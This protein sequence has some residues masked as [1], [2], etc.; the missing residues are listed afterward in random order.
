MWPVFA[1]HPFI[2]SAYHHNSVWPLTFHTKIWPRFVSHN[3]PQVKKPCYLTWPSTS[4]AYLINIESTISHLY[5][6]CLSVIPLSSCFTA[7]ELWPDI[8]PY[9]TS[10]P[11]KILI[12]HVHSRSIFILNDLWHL[13]LQVNKVSKFFQE[14]CIF[15]FQ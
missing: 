4:I 12:Q 2:L 6:L 7:G 15:K 3:V 8:W 13:I 5:W 1:S 9:L 14:H 11:N 10:D